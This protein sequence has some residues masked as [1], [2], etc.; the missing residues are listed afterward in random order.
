M[1]KRLLAILLLVGLFILDRLTKIFALKLLSEGVFDFAL[2]FSFEL[3]LNPGI[4]FSL[5][6]PIW[7]TLGFSVLILAVL[8]AI[9]IKSFDQS[10]LFFSLSLLWLGAFS[11]FLDR[12]HHLAVID[13]ISVWQ[14][15]I[16]NLAD[17]YIVV[18]VILLWIYL[19]KKKTPGPSS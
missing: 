12:I 13:F 1:Q 17:V 4:A 18:A 16:F 15:P 8:M 3:S 9:I 2:G 5:S 14:F 19:Y 11:N 6:L 10:Y 7:I